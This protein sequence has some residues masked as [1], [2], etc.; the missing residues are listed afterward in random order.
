MTEI[1]LL[2]QYL[3]H[4]VIPQKVP[5]SKAWKPFFVLLSFCLVVDIVLGLTF[6]NDWLT[7]W[8]KITNP[9]ALEDKLYKEGLVAAVFITSVV[10]PLIEEYLFRAYLTGFVCNNVVLPLNL[11][12]ILVKLFNITTPAILWPLIAIAVVGSRVIFILL[13]RSKK[14]KI[15]F[16]RFYL[17]HYQLYFYVSAI[18]FGLIHLNNYEIKNFIPLVTVLLVMSQLFAGLVLGYVR[19]KWGLKWSMGFHAL[20]NLFFVLLLFAF[21]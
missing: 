18:A 2:L 8:L 5:T 7:N 13:K 12:L 1:K 15:S 16:A 4:P 20:H 10:A 6:N 19:I 21:S 17:H 9:N 14:L 11:C 3:K